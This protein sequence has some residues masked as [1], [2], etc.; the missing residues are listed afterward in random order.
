[1]EELSILSLFPA[2]SGAR[3]PELQA[4]RIL[5]AEIC[6]ETFAIRLN[7]RFPAYFTRKELKQLQTDLAAC[8]QAQAVEIVPRFPPEALTDQAVSDLSNLLAEVYGPARGILSG[9]TWTLREDNLYLRLKHN[10]HEQIGPYLHQAEAYLSDCFGRTVHVQV[11]SGSEL[12]AEEL[13]EQT[14]QIRQAA[15]MAIPEPVRTEKKKKPVSDMILGKSF[16]DPP[17]PMDELTLDLTRVCVEGQVVALSHKELTRQEAWVV[18]FDMT[19]FTNSIRINGFMEKEKAAPILDRVKPGMWLRVLGKMVYNKYDNENVLQPMAIMAAQREQ[20]QDTAEEKRVELHLHTKMSAMD[21]LTDTEEA[22]KQAARWGHKAIAITDHGVVQSFPDAMKAG[23]KYGVKI[24][25][26]VEAYYVND[27]DDRVAVHGEGNARFSDEYVAFDLETTGL[28]SRTDEIIE[29]GAVILRDG[30]PAERFESF[31]NPGRKLSQ[32]IIDLTGITDDMLKDAPA[33]EQVLPEF[34]AFCGDRPLAA[35]NADF[36]VGFVRQACQR[37]GYPYEPTYVDTLVMAQNLLPD[38]KKYKLNLVADALHL[39][40]FHHHRASDD[41]VTVAYMLPKFFAMLED[42][43]VEDLWQVNSKMQE[44]RTGMKIT[45]RQARHMIILAK[46]QAGLK[47]LYRLVSYGHLKYYKRVPRIPKSELMR[48]REGLIIGSACESGEL[49][50]AIVEGKSQQDLKRIASFYD[51]LEIQPLC[52][53]QFLIAEGTASDEEQLRDYNRTVAA[54]AKE[55]GK[56]LVATGDVHFLNPEDE[57]YRRILLATKGYKDADRELPLYF[58]TTDE[59]LEEFS[60][61][62]EDVAWEAVVTNPNRIADMCQELRPVPTGLFAPKIE[63]SAQQLKDLVYGRLHELYGDEPPE[64]VTQRVETELGDIIHCEYDVIYMIAQKLVAK[65]NE[66]GYLVGS[67]GSVGSSIVAYLSGITE[68]NSFPPHYRCPSCRYTTFDVPEDAACGADLPDAV[69][70]R[71][72]ASL[73]KDGFNIPFQTFLG[74]GGDKVP[75]IDL[76]FS[77]EYQARAHAY[78]VEMFGKD[79]VFRAGTIGTLA[80]KTAY[81]YVRHYMDDHGIMKRRCEVDR[82]SAACVGIRRTTGQHPGGIVVLPYG[83]DIDTFTPL[84]HPADDVSSDIITTH[85]EYHSIEQNLLKLDMLGKGDPTM[86]RMLEDLTGVDAVKDIPLDAPEV[87]SLFKNTDALGI[88][89]DQIGGCRLGVMGI[90]EFNTDFAMQMLIEAKPD[91]VADLVRIAGLAHGTDVW[92]GNTQDLI[93][94]GTATL[95]TAI[96]TRDDIMLY[97]IKTGLE[98]AM[99]FDIMENV[100]KGKVA[101]GKCDKWPGYKEAM[102]EHDVPEWYIESC[103]KIKYMF[104]KAH[105]A[106][107]VMMAW[108]IAWYKIHYP[109]AFYASYYTIRASGFDYELMCLGRD[110]LEKNLALFKAR[111]AGKTAG[112]ETSVTEDV[113]SADSF[114]SDDSDLDADRAEQGALSHKDLL[115]LRDMRVA[116]EMYERGFEFAPLDIYKADPEVFTVTEDGRVMPSISSISGMGLKAAESVARAAK[117]GEFLSRDDFRERTKV[118]QTM[119]EKMNELGLLGSVPETNQLSFFDL[120]Q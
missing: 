81:G 7:T 105:A 14:Q 27:V 97:L 103:Q 2:Y 31:V 107:Y 1:M 10:G 93:L 85:F 102:E 55:L 35:H 37:L 80:E 92:S 58:K 84:Q 72:G 23:K 6:R 74:F 3:Q 18:N 86:I 16:K 39:P 68:V 75:D 57:I 8:C 29:F 45:D 108:R 99:A 54:L 116:Q 34:L 79:H 90:P 52:N 88:T 109:L 83:E 53:N 61:L 24:L 40:E 96:S 67:R 101:G 60:Y 118:S 49:F 111:R 112:P 66:D 56:P 63:N 100:R 62:G 87:L 9:C 32:K 119:V 51:Y 47:N 110:V 65:S 12:S 38:L 64:L 95:K 69:C 43:G 42:S 71:C 36:D 98:P 5:G 25:Y 33:L 117:D 104:P 76:N 46:N 41:A 4:T 91:S 114:G 19:D 11:E 78:T 44:L 70:P 22:V 30:K 94:S 20:R 82:I 77:G 115:T 113:P 89:P 120:L 106:A 73:T 26:G 15:A 17:T 21:A 59:M 50:R 13:F 48:H 28:S